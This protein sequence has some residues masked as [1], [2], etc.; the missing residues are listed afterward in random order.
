MGNS[1]S[2]P[3]P[4]PIVE[5]VSNPENLSLKGSSNDLDGMKKNGSCSTLNKPI[6]HA[7]S[8]RQKKMKGAGS[9]RLVILIFTIVKNLHSQK[10][11]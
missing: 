2:V 7:P 8:E 9:A 4:K 3:D 1:K 6:I 10:Q 5:N 11:H